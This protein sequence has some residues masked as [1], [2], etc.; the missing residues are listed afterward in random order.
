MI[1]FAK[2]PPDDSVVWWHKA[3]INRWIDADSAVVMLDRGFNEFKHEARIRLAMIDAPERFTDEGKSA[4]AF[5]NEL[6]PAGSEVLIYSHRDSSGRYGRILAEVC[7]RGINVNRAILD[8][9]HAVI[10]SYVR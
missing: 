4:T 7:I 6:C 2:P 5:V 10:P 1:S 9:K 3:V 8:A